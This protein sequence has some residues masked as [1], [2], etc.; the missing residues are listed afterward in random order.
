MSDTLYRE[1]VVS[2]PDIA[3]GL[4]RFIK[5][6][7]KAYC[8]RKT[9]LRVI[10]TE[11]EQDRL[12]TQIAFYFGVIIK[13]LAEHAWVDGKQFSKEAWHEYLAQQFLPTKE[14]VL[15]SGEI[16]QRRQSIARGHIGV[17]AMTAYIT[18]VQAYAATE[19]GIEFD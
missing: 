8:E 14:V 10:V 3:Q 9:P 13:G 15:P 6:N 5:A 4:W 11:D 17:K 19:F 12:D 1:F 7:A 16:I 2:G 18:Q